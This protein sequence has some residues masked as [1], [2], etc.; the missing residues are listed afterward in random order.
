MKQLK[1]LPALLLHFPGHLW[2]HR[3]CLVFQPEK[4]K[5][6]LQSIHRKS[7]WLT[8]QGSLSKQLPLGPVSGCTHSHRVQQSRDACSSKVLIIPQSHSSV[9]LHDSPQ[10]TTTN[11]VVTLE[12]SPSS[13]MPRKHCP[14]AL[15]MPS[16]NTHKLPPNSFTEKTKVKHN[17]K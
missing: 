6:T 11:A 9:T 4:K 5:K 7:P 16:L 8:Q 14:F 2:D 17:L 15:L 10:Q 1:H 3:S 13:V 12:A